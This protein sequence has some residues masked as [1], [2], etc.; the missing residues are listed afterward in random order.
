LEYYKGNGISE[1]LL[2]F[3]LQRIKGSFILGQGLEFKL[4]PLEKDHEDMEYAT[5]KKKLVVWVAVWCRKKKG[6]YLASSFTESSLDCVVST[7]L[8]VSTPFLGKEFVD[9]DGERIDFQ[10]RTDDFF[11]STGV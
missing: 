8:N 2:T 6:A 11:S 5:K 10:I 9:W 3:S 1:D 7:S 4:G